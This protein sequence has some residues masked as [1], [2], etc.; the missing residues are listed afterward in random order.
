MEISKS[1]V[2]V[3]EGVPIIA[4]KMVNDH[5]MAVEILNLG[6]IITK[7][8]VPDA[9]G[10]SENIVLGYEEIENYFTNPSYMGCIAGRTAGRIAEGVVDI[11]DITYRLYQNNNG[12][13]LHGGKEGF[14]KKI[15][16]GSITEDES[17]ISI[18][19]TYMSPDGEEHY[20]G[21]LH[22]TVIYTLNN[23]N[24]LII[25]HQAVTDK[26]TI[27]NMT[28]HS[29]FNLSGNG[30]RSIQNHMLQMGANQ[31]CE[32]DEASLPTGILLDVTDT[33]FDFTM[34]KQ[35]QQD[36]GATHT[37]LGYAHGY[38][39]PWVLHH[40]DSADIVFY[41]P[42]SRRVMEIRTNQ[43]AVVFYS[44]NFTDGL[45]LS[46]GEKPNLHY[47]A[48]FETQRLP[49]GKNQVFADQSLLHPGEVYENKTIF[50]FYNQCSDKK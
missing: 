25:A 1:Q 32:I 5:G 10:I 37:Q 43:P 33:P 27:V 9:Q 16:D 4:Y 31:F 22:V 34:P 47:G 19:L 17:D 15:W 21:N 50:K 26:T 41:D 13:T 46:N 39:H 20:P 14:N 38:D 11:G 42:E 7:I 49:I 35:V 24:E 45:K 23:D 30:K 36:L 3:K 29:Y 44:M 28:N 2:A 48:C 6:G 18:K 12:N 8:I 40:K